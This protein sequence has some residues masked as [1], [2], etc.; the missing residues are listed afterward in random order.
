MREENILFLLYI[1]SDTFLIERKI[2]KPI[3]FN[4]SEQIGIQLPYVASSSS[5]ICS[6][7]KVLIIRYITTC[8]IILLRMKTGHNGLMARELYCRL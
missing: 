6:K 8:L 7:K 2:I 4:M 3:R 5:D 1:L